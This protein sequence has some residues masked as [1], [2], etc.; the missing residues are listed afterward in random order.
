VNA[1]SRQVYRGLDIGTAKPAESERGRVPHHLIDVRGLDSPLDVAEFCA[2]ARAAIREIAARGRLILVVGGS[3]LYLRVLRGGIFCAP[4]A[5]PEIRERLEKTASK[6]GIG[7]LHDRLRE[8]D[9]AA[10][11]RI[12][13]HDLYRITRALEV[14]ELTGEPISVHQARHA[15]SAR[16]FDSLTVGITMERKALYENINRRFDA[17]I[18]EG[19]VEEVRG[20]LAAGYNPGRPPLS[21]IGY[22]HIAAFVRG[23]MDLAAAAEAAKRD[24]RR[25]AKSQMT[26]FR[27]DSE[28]LWVDA[29][30]A[31]QRAFELFR[32]FFGEN[33]DRPMD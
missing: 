7:Y 10:A 19:L 3:G 27:S 26:W 32:G 11:S 22:K 31:A 28:I 9:P 16:D 18:A 6:L 25:L 23:E 20:L 15:F 2:L 1:D 21:T 5:S 14:F 29:E 30:R 13:Y 24:S 12:G 4:P 33:R 17:M 8:V